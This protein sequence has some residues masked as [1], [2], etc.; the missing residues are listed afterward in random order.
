MITSDGRLFTRETQSTKEFIPREALWKIIGRFLAK[1]NNRDQLGIE[2]RVDKNL[3]KDSP[4]LNFRIFVIEKRLRV[5]SSETPSTISAYYVYNGWT[6]Q[7]STMKRLI[8][9]RAYNAAF[10]LNKGVNYVR[11]VR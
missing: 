5:S 2:F 4:D 10:L 9:A 6:F 8:D 11:D 3:C 7:A 1:V